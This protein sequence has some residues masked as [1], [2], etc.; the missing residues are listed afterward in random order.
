M[1]RR[2]IKTAGFIYLVI[3]TVILF[4]TTRISAEEYYF[5]GMTTGWEDYLNEIPD[6]LKDDLG[7]VDLDN[8]LES[9]EGLAEKFNLSFWLSKVLEEVE[10][11][12]FPSL[13]MATAILGVLVISSSLNLLSENLLGGAGKEIFSFCCNLSLST[14]V[15]GL[16]DV[17]VSLCSSYLDRLC[18]IMNVMLPITEIFYLTEASLTQLAVHKSAMLLF[19]GVTSNLNNLVLKPMFSVLFGFTISGSIFEQFG[20]T[21]FIDG[22]KKAVMTIISIFTMLFSFVLG[23]QTVLARGADSLG[24]KTARLALGSFIPIIGGTLSE[25]LTTVKEGFGFIRTVTGV[26]GI[27]VILF[28]VLPIICTIF[29]NNLVLSFCHM[30]AEIL[31]CGNG[32][33]IIHEVKA[34]LSIL[35]AIVYSTTLLFIM[36]LILF[37][38]VGSGS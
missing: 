31:N 29:V 19:V 12:F 35:N 37:A 4:L 8:P 36:A 13:K 1:K 32:A 14:V 10:K 23:T 15:I 16:A 24:L 2:I 34:V 30:V 22:F 18:S 17:I 9:A 7:D 28:L 25:A 6:E 38:K 27:V 33:K 3:F 26:G 21:G 11:S 5:D 20:I